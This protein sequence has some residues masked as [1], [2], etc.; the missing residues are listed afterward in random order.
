MLISN[1]QIS[2]SLVVLMKGY[3][4]DKILLIFEKRGK[5]LLKVKWS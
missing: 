1:I 5:K 2:L 3:E 4:P